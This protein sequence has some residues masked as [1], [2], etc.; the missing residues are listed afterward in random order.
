M[1][2]IARVL[3][4][5]FPTTALEVETLKHLAMLS[6]AGLFVWLILMTYRL[7]VER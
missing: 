6:G 5:N 7:V 4:R 1:T 3:A 2:A